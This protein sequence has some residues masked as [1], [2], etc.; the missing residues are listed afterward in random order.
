VSGL[1]F[2]ISAGNTDSPKTLS[3]F[4]SLSSGQRYLVSGRTWPARFE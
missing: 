1:I 4:S 2:R 3:R